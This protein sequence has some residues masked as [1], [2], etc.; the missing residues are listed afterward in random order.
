MLLLSPV[1]FGWRE[2]LVRLIHILMLIF[3]YPKS[4]W[5]EIFTSSL[6]M[7][8]AIEAQLSGFR[9]SW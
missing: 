6:I 1:A 5:E 2:D 3:R 4:M 8:F 7:D 9:G